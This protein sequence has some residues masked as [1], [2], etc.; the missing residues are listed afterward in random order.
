[1]NSE[2]FGDVANR[3]LS[4]VS[5][6]IKPSTYAGYASVLEL[7][8][9]PQLGKRSI[10]RLKEADINNFTEI[11][12]KNGRADGKGGLSIKTVRDLLSVINTIMDYAYNETII[13]N[14]ITITYPKLENQSIRILSRQ[15]QSALEDVLRI[16]LDIHKLGIML[17]LY[18]GLRIGEICALRWA[19]IS[20]EFDS[21]SVR[22]T[23]Q[24]I[25]DVTGEKGKTKIHIDTP[26][27]ER[28]IRNIPIP[29][30][31]TGDLRDFALDG[32][33]Y[34]LSTDNLLFTEPRT[35]QNHF[36]RCVKAAN[37]SGANFHATRHTFA[38]RCIEAGV[39]V[40]TLSEMLG[41]ANINMTINRYVISSFEQK[42]GEI[43]KLESYTGK[44]IGL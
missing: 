31:L 16:D 39:D 20:P 32:N 12:L 10:K 19:D 18:T 25:K 28:S 6:N 4:A 15:E 37:I 26:R 13:S 43:N 14:R 36:A 30:F 1:M 23:L 7:H 38:A 22:Q 42:R 21:L 8:I 2:T 33:S 5:A 17:C 35:M 27:C 9:L 3:W 40:K 41:H 34:F 24:R 44:C 11:K 29:R